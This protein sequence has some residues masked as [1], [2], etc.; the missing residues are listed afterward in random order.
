MSAGLLRKFDVE[1]VSI[2]GV[3]PNQKAL[4]RRPEE[5]VGGA[6]TRPMYPVLG[7][8]SVGQRAWCFMD[9]D[10][11]VIVAPPLGATNSERIGAAETALV[12]NET[13][14]L[15]AEVLYVDGMLD[16]RGTV[17]VL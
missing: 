4:I 14:L 2:S 9:A 11:G 5:P 1:I 15:R 12:N 10:G 8:V 16:V 17:R 7:S 3:A 13:Q 6:P